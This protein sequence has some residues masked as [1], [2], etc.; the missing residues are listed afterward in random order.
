M[1]WFSVCALAHMVVLSC[2]MVSCAAA[3]QQTTLDHPHNTTE[4]YDELDGLDE[5]VASGRIPGIAV[6]AAKNGE[7]QILDIAGMRDT[8]TGDPLKTDDLFHLGSCTKAM[9]ATLAASIIEDGLLS[10]DTT[11][12]KA[13]PG[14][15][16]ELDPWYRDVTIEQLLHHRAGVAERT[17]RMWEFETFAAIQQFEGTPTEIRKQAVQYVLSKPPRSRDTTR[18]EYSNV[19]YMTVGYVLETVMEKPFEQ[20][21]H[22]RVFLPLGMTSAG[23]GLPQG[24][25]QPRG[26]HQTHDG[27]LPVAA[28]D[29]NKA[30]PAYSP[31]GEVHATLHDWFLFAQDQMRGYRGE[32]GTLLAPDSYRKL[33][34]PPTGGT[35]AMGWYKRRQAWANVALTHNGTNVTFYAVATLAPELD[36]CVLVATNCGPPTAGRACRDA[37]RLAIDQL[38]LSGK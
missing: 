18:M 33:H 31:S 23:F 3:M 28:E 20:L 34:E 17:D 5:L 7:I 19:S 21:M 27:F 2:V 14:L 9:T 32:P 8:E 36:A 25:S 11:L 13:L 37:L 1:K 35:Y 30:S 6:L 10:W 24:Q 26:H 38:Q 22:E 4:T 15:V 16:D 12:A 29:Q